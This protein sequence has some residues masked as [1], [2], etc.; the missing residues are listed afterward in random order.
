M[1]TVVSRVFH[2]VCRSGEAAGTEDVL[3]GRQGT[4]G[5]LLAGVNNPL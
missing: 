3:Q 4:A 5:D 2:N 1:M